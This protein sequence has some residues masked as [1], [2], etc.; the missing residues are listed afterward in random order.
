[1]KNYE[2][3]IV[4]VLVLP[5]EDMIVTSMDDSSENVGDMPDFA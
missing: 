2:K 1:M 4:K 3:V 5:L